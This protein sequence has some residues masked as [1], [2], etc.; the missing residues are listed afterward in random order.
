M[1][2]FVIP[3]ILIATIMIGGIFAF[4]PVQQASTVHI[5][6]IEA[7]TGG[8]VAILSDLIAL[9]AWVTGGHETLSGHD[10]NI[11]EMICETHGGDYVEGSFK[12]IIL[13]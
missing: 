5:E 11:A 4:N 9:H 6:I 3:S 10:Y 13:D 1:N 8:D 12:C 2:K 7:I